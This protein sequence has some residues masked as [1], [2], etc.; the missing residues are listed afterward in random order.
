[1]PRIGRYIMT[2]LPRSR[3]LQEKIIG[4]TTHVRIRF[5]G[6]GRLPIRREEF[7]LRRIE[8]QRIR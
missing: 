3:M 8:S 2:L 5:K 4:V 1:M 7:R 6:R